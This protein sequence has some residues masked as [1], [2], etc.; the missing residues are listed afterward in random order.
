MAGFD[1][2][3]QYELYHAKELYYFKPF[4]YVD[5]DI[6]GSGTTNHIKNFLRR[7]DFLDLVRKHGS[8]YIKWVIRDEDTPEVMAYKMYGS[9][10]LYWV[11]LMINRMEDPYF[12]W[13]LTTDDLHEYTVAKYGE[14]HIHD[15]HHYESVDTGDAYDLPD[16]II[17]DEYYPHKDEISNN[18]Y[19]LKLN[20][21]KRK[22][23]ILK[24]DYI[25]LVKS[26]WENLNQS[27]FTKVR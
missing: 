15:L 25:H 3:S 14:D 2:Y 23:L 7:F 17:V 19:E 12:S 24:K 26:E 8:I 11:I 21:V 10:H 20:D 6:D 22:I 5:Y 1:N 4:P 9:T 18:D 27:K 13:P 16:G